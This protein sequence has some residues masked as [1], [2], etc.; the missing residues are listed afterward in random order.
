MNIPKKIFINEHL[1]LFS[2]GQIRIPN[3]AIQIPQLTL[4]FWSFS[5]KFEKGDSNPSYSDSNPHS[6]KFRLT[7]TIRIPHE[8]IRI[9]IP[10]RK[11]RLTDSNLM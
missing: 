4:Q 11:L 7:K 1:E 2:S 10:V 8:E 6:K 3:K 5:S 9:Q